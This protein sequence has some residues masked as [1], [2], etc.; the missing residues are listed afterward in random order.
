MHAGLFVAHHY[1]RKIGILL[2]RLADTGY[3]P[4]AENSQHSG[5]EFVLLAIPLDVLILQEAQ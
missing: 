2:Q 4:V 3:V 1:V 5:E